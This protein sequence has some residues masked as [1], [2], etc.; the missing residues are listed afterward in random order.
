[1]AA[2]L[3][4]SAGNG[5][6]PHPG[7][8]ENVIQGVDQ[9]ELDR[10][11]NL[12]G[13]SVTEHYTLRNG[14][15]QATAEMT[16]AAIYSK[17]AGKSY[18]VLSRSGSSALQTGVLDKLLLEE[19][20]MSRGNTRQHALATSANYKMRILGEESLAGRQCEVLEIIPR[21]K[22]THLLKGR[23]WVDA[24]DHSLVRIEGKP[25]AGPSF[26]SGRP[27]IVR[28]YE[29]IDGFSLATKSHALSDSFLL[30]R[31]ELTIEYSDY[32]VTGTAK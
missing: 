24:E 14:R 5:A 28:E 13:Y 27:M 16:V 3:I 11:T 4:C 29:R 15:F 17:G 9:A 20:E 1:M 18:Q 8:E 32:K 25:S 6:A 23:A 22:S 12:A 10:E 26:W 19:A 21:T 30:G 7:R 2:A 31:T